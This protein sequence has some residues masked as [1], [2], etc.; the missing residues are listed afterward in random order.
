M[1][2]SGSGSNET[3][4][5]FI[6]YNSNYNAIPDY[7]GY[8]SILSGSSTREGRG[9]NLIGQKDY[10]NIRFFLGG[11]QTSDLKMILDSDGDLGIGTTNPSAKLQ[12]KDGDIYIEDINKGVIMKSPDGNCW[13]IT[14][15]NTGAMISNLLY[16]C[17]CFYNRL[18]PT[19]LL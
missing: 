6:T 5:A 1:E 13:R 11:T 17:P 15:D 7:N 4:G 12:V 19:S 2:F 10:A 9:I 14:I 8:V 16:T 18:F 3:I